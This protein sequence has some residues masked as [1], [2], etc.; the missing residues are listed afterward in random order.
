MIKMAK[1]NIL[2][3]RITKILTNMGKQH[4]KPPM[5]NDCCGAKALED[6]GEAKK[7]RDI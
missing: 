1:Q 7:C 2:P 5:C 3:W 6:P 4:T